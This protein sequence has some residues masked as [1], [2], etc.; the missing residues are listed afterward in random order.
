MKTR[1]KGETETETANRLSWVMRGETDGNQESR[2]QER[3]REGEREREEEREQTHVSCWICTG[4]KSEG[5]LWNQLSCSLG[6]VASISAHLALLFTCVLICNP[7]MIFSVKYLFK[8]IIPF[9]YISNDIPLP[10][11]PSTNLDPTSTLPLSFAS[12]AP[13]LHHLSTLGHQTSPG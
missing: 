8:L 11:Y 6:L 13:L 10:I 5:N 1:K 12:P 2:H 3:A 7:L 4:Q 9:V